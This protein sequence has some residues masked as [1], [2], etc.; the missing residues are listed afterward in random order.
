MHGIALNV[1]TD[2]GHFELINPCGMADVEVTTMAAEVGRQVALDEVAEAF[3]F[4]FGRV[5]DC[6]AKLQPI[7]GREKAQRGR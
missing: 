3:V 6:A 1:D 2:L 4:H 5:F 7:P